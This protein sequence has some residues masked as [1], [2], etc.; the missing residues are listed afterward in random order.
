MK[1]IQKFWKNE[2]GAEL[3]EIAAYAGIFIVA[4]IV[5][6]TTLGPALSGFFGGLGTRLVGS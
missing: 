3:L 2:E 1:M 5:G 6:L 4:A